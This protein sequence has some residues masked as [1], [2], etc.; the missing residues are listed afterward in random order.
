MPC[1][2]AGDGLADQGACWWRIWTRPVCGSRTMTTWAGR[3][4][5]PASPGRLVGAVAVRR[6]WS[7]DSAPTAICTRSAG[8]GSRPGKPVTPW[9]VGVAL[10]AAL[11]VTA[12]GSWGAE[13]VTGKI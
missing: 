2:P 4:D 12:D 7:P 5:G 3:G 8:V 11:T 10:A 13:L 1:F 9:P 6:R